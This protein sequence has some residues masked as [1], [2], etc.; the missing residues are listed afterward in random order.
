VLEGITRK[1]V[2]DVA[3]AN[4]V[5]IRI[6]V[7]PVSLAYDCDELFMCTTAGGIMPITLLDGQP[8]KD[9][10]LGPITKAIWDEYWTM[11]WSDEYSFAID[12]SVSTNE[13][14]KDTTPGAI[15]DGSTTGV[16]HKMN[17]LTNGFPNAA[18]KG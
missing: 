13:S 9:G 1:S 8:V 15:S 3:R 6:E 14:G 12:Y 2:F 18:V 5:E 7:V 16:E 17:G 10:K 11:H 4:N